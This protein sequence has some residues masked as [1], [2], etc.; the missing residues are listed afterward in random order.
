ML[1][2]ER[3][4]ELM[5]EICGQELAKLEAMYDLLN[6]LNKEGENK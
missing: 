5:N 1:S 3:E 6:V 2:E 4:E